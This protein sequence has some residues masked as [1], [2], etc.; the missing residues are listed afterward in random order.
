ML[1]GS[2][3]ALLFFLAKPADASHDASTHGF[4]SNGCSAYKRNGRCEDG[5]PGSL[6]DDCEYGTDCTDC[7]TRYL[8]PSPLPSRRLDP[9]RAY[10][11]AFT[12][13]TTLTHLCTPTSPSLDSGAREPRFLNRP[14]TSTNRPATK[15]FLSRTK[16]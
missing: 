13:H 7:Y 6:T 5:G 12:A 2:L 8:P 4:C 14:A 15:R 3:A 11:T 10:P 1:A 16:R 9:N